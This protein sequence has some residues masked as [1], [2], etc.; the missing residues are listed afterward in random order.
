MDIPDHPVGLSPVLRDSIL[1]VSPIYH[2]FLLEGEYLCVKLVEYR[3]DTFV[4]FVVPLSLLG[5]QDM[6]AGRQAADI[7][8]TPVYFCQRSLSFI[9]VWSCEGANVCSVHYLLKGSISDTGKTRIGVLWGAATVGA[10]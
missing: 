4:L 2:H 9:I 6:D 7:G 3:T 10:S 8:L 5:F 1:V